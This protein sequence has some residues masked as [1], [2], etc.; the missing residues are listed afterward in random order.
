MIADEPTAALDPDSADTV[1]EL[2][3]ETASAQGT[4]LIL[5][6]H[7]LPRME[8]FAIPRRSLTVSAEQGAVVSRLEGAPC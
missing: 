3:L 7:D 5:S 6:S 2:L 4:G 8:R 1:L